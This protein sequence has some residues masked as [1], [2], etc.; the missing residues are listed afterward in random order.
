[1]HNGRNVGHSVDYPHEQAYYVPAEY[2]PESRVGLERFLDDHPERV[3]WYESKAG[4]ET[5]E[6]FGWPTPV[7]V[8]T[9]TDDEKMAKELDSLVLSLKKAGFGSNVVLTATKELQPVFLIHIRKTGERKNKIPNEQVFGNGWAFSEMNGAFVIGELKGAYSGRK[10]LEQIKVQDVLD[11]YRDS[12]GLPR[13]VDFT[14]TADIPYLYRIFPGKY[15]A[16]AA[17]LFQT[18]YKPLTPEEIGSYFDLLYLPSRDDRRTRLGAKG[19]KP[20]NF[21]HLENWPENEKGIQLSP[22]FFMV[23]NPNPTAPDGLVISQITSGPQDFTSAS[24]RNMLKTFRDANTGLLAGSRLAVS[25]NGLN[26]QKLAEVVRV[27]NEAA[28]HEMTS[29]SGSADLIIFNMWGPKETKIGKEYVKSLR[30]QRYY[31]GKSGNGQNIGVVRYDVP[32]VFASNPGQNIGPGGMVATAY[33]EA[34]DIFEKLKRGEINVDQPEYSQWKR[35]YSRILH[36][37]N[38]NGSELDFDD[39]TIIMVMAGGRAKRFTPGDKT[40]AL[41]PIPLPNGKDFHTVM[42]FALQGAYVMTR[43]LKQHGSPGLVVVSGDTI[44]L[45]YQQIK[46]GL[47]AVSSPASLAE[48]ADKLGM[49]ATEEGTGRVLTFDEKLPA[50][51]IR[52][53][54]NLKSDVKARLQTSAGRDE[55]LLNANVPILITA[56]NERKDGKA[57]RQKF[58]EALAKINSTIKEFGDR[59]LYYEVDTS[60]DFYRVLG[61]AA[62]F[63]E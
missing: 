60:K 58:S 5:G 20:G 1:M 61:F 22:D 59:G 54:S 11:G 3:H 17:G 12:M 45:G 41:L 15:A 48:V 47:N 55:R 57:Q 52:S 38:V 40:N 34:R 19:S 9:G 26:E 51:A 62:Y 39:L 14:Q 4:V 2:M 25:S 53:H 63:F 13:T 33:E 56:Y 49:F 16:P 46:N 27:R 7:A 50:E 44:F 35:I 28:W 10:R 6:I 23:A 37:R 18:L 36:E 24:S 30:G 29:D 8:I 31:P 42:S 21:L 32:V 43:D